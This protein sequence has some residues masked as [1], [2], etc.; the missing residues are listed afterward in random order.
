M[1]GGF[2][3][4][5]RAFELEMRKKPERGAGEAIIPHGHYCCVYAPMEH[6][7][8]YL[9][10][11]ESEGKFMWQVFKRRKRKSSKIRF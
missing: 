1:A 3:G 8:R 9:K 11:S 7:L 4:R 6:T 2:I 5:S 10:A